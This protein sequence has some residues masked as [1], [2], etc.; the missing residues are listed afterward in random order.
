[1]FRLPYSTSLV[2]VFRDELIDV[3][4]QASSRV[5]LEVL[6]YTTVDYK[7]DSC[8]CVPLHKPSQ[9]ILLYCGGKHYYDGW[10]FA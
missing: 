4:V 3:E 7:R 5:L 2:R 6:L 9:Q 8:L 10:W 1:M